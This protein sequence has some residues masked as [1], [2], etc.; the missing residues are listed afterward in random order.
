MEKPRFQGRRP[1]ALITFFIF[2]LVVLV[3]LGFYPRVFKAMF[4]SGPESLFGGFLSGVSSGS[5]QVG[6]LW[7]NYL[8]LVAVKKENDALKKELAILSRRLYQSRDLFF[9]NAQL[10]SLLALRDRVLKPG[11]SCR[12]MAINPT[13]GHRTFLLDCGSLDGIE[14]KSGVVGSFAVIGYVVR[15]FPHFSQVLWIEDN[16][17]ALE[18]KIPGVP[19]SGIIHGQGQGK[20]LRLKYLP[21][22]ADVKVGDP[23]ET[24]GEDGIF[25]EGI[26]IGSIAALGTREKMLFHQVH[27][28]P[29]EHL[30]DLHF[31]YVFSPEHHWSGH[32]LVGA[33]VK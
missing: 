11:K 24:T 26:P 12:V 2:L 28:T 23:V 14:E 22:L 15:V 13:S 30:S 19:D 4:V 31:A 16:Y 20:A 6:S 9:E 33:V 25:P 5:R 1:R 27:V 18:A 7:S 29:A 10:K 3:I 21:I 17:F 32:P 8:D